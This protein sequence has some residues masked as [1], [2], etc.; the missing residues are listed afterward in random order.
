MVVASNGNA[1]SRERRADLLKMTWL[2]GKGIYVILQ[3]YEQ[4]VYFHDGFFACNGSR[5]FP[6]ALASAVVV[7]IVGGSFRFPNIYRLDISCFLIDS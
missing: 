2:E 7:P 1:R 5:R 4:V 6:A 3:M